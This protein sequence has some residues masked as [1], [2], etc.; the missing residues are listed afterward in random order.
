MTRYCLLCTCEME[1]GQLPF[2]ADC[3][4]DLE[5]LPAEKRMA[6]CLRISDLGYAQRQ[7][8]SLARL[9]DQLAELI[10]LSRRWHPS[11]LSVPYP[12]KS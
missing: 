4:R 12:S 2:C 7:S 3:Q 6:I 8:E 5:S 1:L 11:V 9:A 10:E